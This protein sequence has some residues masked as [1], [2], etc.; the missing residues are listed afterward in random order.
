[1][2]AAETTLSRLR[3]GPRWLL[4]GSLALNLFFVGVA[5]AL[6]IRGPEP[7]RRWNRDV[8]VRVERLAATLPKADGDIV[9]NA[10]QAN[11]DAIASA[12]AAYHAA[13]ESIRDTLRQ[14]SFNVEAMRAAM[15]KTRTAR[16][17]YDQV[18]EDV[19]ADAAAKMS[20]EGRHALA[21]WHRPKSKSKSR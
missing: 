5:I 4:L 14:D 19:F 7:A 17:N 13:R 10:M 18:I 11:H 1:M 3:G 8:F 15:A 20:P 12:Q 21:N 2:S 6:A 16:Q 9:R